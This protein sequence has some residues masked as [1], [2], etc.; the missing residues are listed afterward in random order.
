MIRK[1]MEQDLGDILAIYNHAILNT[2]AIYD[3]Q[4]HTLE[5][6]QAWYQEKARASLPLIVYT[7]EDRTVGF[8]TFGPFRPYPAYHYTVEHSVYVH[9]DHQG[10]GIGKALLSKI[11][12]LADCEGYATMVAGIDS[13]NRVSIQLHKNS[14]FHYAG[15]IHKAGYKF[16]KW[17]DLDFYQRSLSGPASPTEG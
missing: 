15:R 14:G 13:E 17:L 1:A 6:R 7:M 11:V 5:D 4:V 10:K 3:Y 16:G 2:T 12:E 8:A 9:P